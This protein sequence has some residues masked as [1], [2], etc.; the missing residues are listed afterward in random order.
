MT[1]KTDQDSEVSEAVLS[2]SQR[3]Q[4]AMQFKRM[5]TKI[6][7]ARMFA[8]KKF[9]DTKHLKMR[10][11][12]TAIAGIKNRFASGKDYASMAVG[13][14]IAL[15][16]RVEKMKPVVTKIATRLMPKIR[17]K[18]IMRKLN[19][20]KNAV[21]EQSFDVNESFASFA[22]AANPTG[23]LDQ[24]VKYGL[25]DTSMLSTIK[26]AVKKLSSG[27]SLNPNER[28]ATE[29]LI[30]TMLDMVTSSDALFRMAKSELQK[31]CIEFVEDA[32]EQDSE[33]VEV[34]GIYMAK[35]E[36]AT[37]VDDAEEIYAILDSMEEE[38]DAWIQSKISLASD[39]IS[40][41]RDYLEF[42]SEGEDYDEEAPEEGEGEDD[43]FDAENY[44][45]E[46]E[47]ELRAFN[48]RNLDES[49]GGVSALIKKSEKS[50]IEFSIL[51]EVYK[52]GEIAWE[53][54]GTSK[55][56]CEQW[57][58]ARVNSFITGGKTTR[59]DDSDLWE[60]HKANAKFSTFAEAVLEYGT[61]EAR[62]AHARATPGQSQEITTSKYSIDKVMKVL[63]NANTQRMYKLYGEE[64]CCDECKDEIVEEVDWQ[65]VLQEAEFQGKQVTLNE[66]FRTPGE[67]KKF[68][69][70]T[71]GESGK[72]VIVRF[73]DPNME[74]KRDDPERRA[75]F[76]ARHNCDDPGPKWKAKYWSCYQW[77]SGAKVES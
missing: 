67:K 46:I 25:A 66:P 61:D 35:V 24:L 45:E 9:A 49:D 69:V 63:N 53:Q 40:T 15:D 64:A 70:Y 29:S 31:E 50:G 14:K 6:Q 48:A 44:A 23:R 20:S 60:K 10:A 19:A 26:S 59:T 55:F 28:K 33:D 57:A 38:P 17:Q 27:D 3:R 21:R 73:G 5:Q 62:I 77:R 37:L 13:Q 52:R 22:E 74:I 30:M 58:F 65:N 7:R 2:L 41:V 42:S 16:K 11:R 32:E 8:M 56:T 39:Y 18:E 68:A 54:S 34:D 71:T 4:R 36:I 72:T 1:I 47:L 75:S 76:R 12:R 51:D 43:E